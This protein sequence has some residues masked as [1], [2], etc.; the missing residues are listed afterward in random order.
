MVFNKA[1]SGY[2]ARLLPS[3]GVFDVNIDYFENWASNTRSRLFQTRLP[4]HYNDRTP[5]SVIR[6]KKH[7]AL[8]RIVRDFVREK[9]HQFETELQQIIARRQITEFPSEELNSLPLIARVYAL[10]EW[11]ENIQPFRQRRFNLGYETESHLRRLILRFADP[12]KDRI[13]TL[14]QYWEELFS[15][16]DFLRRRFI[17]LAGDDL[18]P[19]MLAEVIDWQKR[20]YMQRISLDSESKPDLYEKMADGEPIVSDRPSLDWEDDPILL[21]LYQSLFKDIGKKGGAPLKF[22]HLMIDE[23]QDLSPIDLAVLLNMLASPAS[24]TLAGDVDQKMV[25]NSGFTDWHNLFDEL[26]LKGQTISTLKVGYRSTFEIMSFG[27]EVL[28]DL[29]RT[30]SFTATRS[31]PPVELF[32]FAGQ[33][34][35][36]YFLSRNLKELAIREPNASTA[37]ICVSPQDAVTYFQLLDRMELQDLRLVADQDFAFSPGIDITDIKQVKGLE[38]DYVILLDVDRINYPDHPYSRYLLHIGATRA[39]HQLW[40]M[41]HRPPSPILPSSLTQRLIR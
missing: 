14:I 9:T 29:T 18:T 39:A 27:H 31:G 17:E 26:G 25:E 41:N 6:F 10:Y 35:L 4:K 2:I 20:Q 30:E 3:L 38:F 7:P 33:G 32:Q 16:F 24:L 5:V 13:D 23:V 40:L 12:E 1:L 11:I 22:G 15:N 21:Y 8:L 36:L 34:E 28:A 37:L 19:A